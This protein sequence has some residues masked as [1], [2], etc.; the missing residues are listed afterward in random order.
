M[1][2]FWIKLWCHVTAAMCL[3]AAPAV[4]AMADA[5]KEN[6][7]YLVIAA[8]LSVIGN[9]AVAAKAYL[10]KASTEDAT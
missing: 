2:P 7:W 4:V 8:V 1:K 10:S 6:F 9:G 5:P 3:T